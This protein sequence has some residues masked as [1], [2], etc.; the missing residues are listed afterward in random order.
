MP[1]KNLF[2]HKIFINQLID[3]QNSEDLYRDFY[4]LSMPDA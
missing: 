3:L 1:I 2:N 4:T